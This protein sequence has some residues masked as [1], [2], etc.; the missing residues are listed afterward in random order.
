MYISVGLGIDFV[1]LEFKSWRVEDWYRSC[2][3][4]DAIGVLTPF[5]VS[6]L[7]KRTSTLQTHYRSHTFDLSTSLVCRSF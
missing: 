6:T 5:G 4:V 3:N 7:S 2:W 1:A